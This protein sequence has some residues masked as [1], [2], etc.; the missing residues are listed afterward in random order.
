MNDQPLILRARAVA[1]D[2]GV[3]SAPGALL[4]RWSGGGPACEILDAGPPEPV[5][6]RAPAGAGRVDLG[7][8]VVLPGLVNA[9]CHLDLTAVGAV[10]MDPATGFA[11]WLGAVRRARPRDHEDIRRSVLLGAERSLAGGVVAIGDIAG[12][13]SVD[14]VEALRESP[15]I[16]VSYVEC[17]GLGTVAE[18]ADRRL[19]GLIAGLTLFDRGVRLGIQPHAPY[20]AGLGLYARAAD[21][22]D[23][24]DLPL[25]THLAE[26]AAERELI[27]DGRGPMRDLLES[28]GGWNAG[29]DAEFG[30]GAS[31]VEH[32][33]HA[34]AGRRW[35]LAHC[36]DC[37]DRDLSIL[38][39]SGAA[40]VYSPRS[41]VFF[42][43]EAEVGPHRWREML[44]RGVT[45]ALGTDS[46]A[47]LAI[48]PGEPL[49][50]L[51]E[52]KALHARGGADPRT[53]LA[54]MTT[55]GARALALP[56]DRFRFTPGPTAGIVAVDA[57][58]GADSLEAI[59]APASRPTLVTRHGT[60]RWEPN[61]PPADHRS[62]QAGP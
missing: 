7:D 29:A 36:N 10:P 55:H 53:L 11:G 5:A 13:W 38:S 28:I 22:A 40:V 12:D 43:R 27:A 30:R 46:A 4:V 49:S 60:R 2:R 8:A 58:R 3:I 25:A 26:S 33:A 19:E 18:D 16:G 21:L 15:L 62:D 6:R 32:L 9:H 59:L 34:L 20:S 44:D 37:T 23:R 31:P 56:E 39:G 61:G 41:C 50:V 47:S 57:P 17:F 54:M 51:D 42:G 45:V 52:A 48:G 1:D 24:H 35:L 14:A